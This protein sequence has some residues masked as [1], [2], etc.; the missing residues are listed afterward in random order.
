MSTC[1]VAIAADHA[2]VGLKE[3]LS[4]D[5]E[6]RGYQVLDLGT[7]GPE[8]VDYPDYGHALAEAVA[9]GQARFG[10]AICG[11]GIGIAIAAN[12]HPGIRAAVCHDALTARL[13][14]RHNDAN[15]L[16]LGARVIGVETAKDCL[17]AFLET[18]FEGGRHE[19]RV[20]KLA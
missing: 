16:A 1:T 4:A 5:L 3:I 13:S 11:T 14:R 20:A 2:G 7:D 9:A 17:G 15:V 18:D 6:S 12:R 10:V 8:S 19:R